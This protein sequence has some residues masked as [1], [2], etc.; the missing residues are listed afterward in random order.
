MTFEIAEGHPLAGR[1]LGLLSRARVELNEL[2]DEVEAHNAQHPIA[3]DDV[4]RVTFYFGQYVE[5]S[6]Q[7][8]ASGDEHR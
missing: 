8:E 1:V 6:E 3:K 4:C 7:V 5:T 2:W